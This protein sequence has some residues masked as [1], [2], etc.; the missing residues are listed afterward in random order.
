MKYVF[1]FT[2]FFL[3]ACAQDFK[4]YQRYLASKDLPA[5][6]L[7]QFPHC[8][9][10]GC[11]KHDLIELN[12]QQ[13]KKID[14]IFPTPSRTPQQERSRVEKAIGVFETIVG[15]MA[16][17][18]KDIHGTFIKM[19]KGQLD[20]VDESTN[21]TIYLDLLRQRGHLTFHEIEQPQ[22]RLPFIGGGRWTHQTA[23]IRDLKTG[24]RYAVDSWF[25]DNGYPAHVV[26][27][28]EWTH[29]WRPPAKEKPKT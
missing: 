2:L 15:A 14:K 29:G 3:S 24:E 20:C 25:E 19:G 18:D 22:I 10:Y 16:G 13:W 27:L 23:T 6:T 9:S 1:V 11:P 4:T 28:D 7:E 12:K 8:H 5:P 17:T 26:P 21:T